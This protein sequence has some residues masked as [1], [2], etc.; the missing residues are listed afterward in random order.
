ME[1]CKERRRYKI[2]IQEDGSVNT[3]GKWCVMEGQHEGSPGGGRSQMRRA[4]SA[5]LCVGWPRCYQVMKSCIS[6][7]LPSASYIFIIP[8]HNE[9][10]VTISILQTRKPKQKRPSDLP[11]FMQLV[12]GRGRNGDQICLISESTLFT[13]K[14]YGSNVGEGAH[15]S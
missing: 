9:T 5:W 11:K 3:L 14:L 8:P 12:I 4:W 13:T 7:T 15:N 10:C 6:K 2:V 1:V